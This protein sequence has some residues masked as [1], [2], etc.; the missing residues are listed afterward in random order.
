MSVAPKRTP[1]W[2][3]W[4]F[5]LADGQ[6]LLE[7]FLGSGPEGSG[8]FLTHFNREK[9]AIRLV[10]ASPAQASD[11]I[12]RWNRAASLSHPHLIRILKSGTCV[13]AD[14]SFAYL[15]TEYADEVLAAVLQDRTLTSQ[16]ALE[17]VCPIADVLEYLHSQNLVHGDVSPENVF[18][19][20]DTVKICC[21]A[22]SIGD[23][24]NDVLG[25]A[26]T[27]AQA[28]THRD[29]IDG[30]SVEALPQPFQEIARN[31]LLAD[32]QSRWSSGD[33]ATWLRSGERPSAIHS[34]GTGR[35]RWSGFFAV[36]A[37]VIVALVAGAFFVRRNGVPATPQ[38]PRAEQ[39]AAKPAEKIPAAS[40]RPSE[41]IVHRV[42][43][44]IPEKA[45]KTIRGRATVVIRVAV[46]PSG[47]VTNAR[48]ERGG[49]RY[50][51]KLAMAAA[52]QWRFAPIENS[53]RREWVLKFEITKTAINVIPT[54]RR[55]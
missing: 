26:R 16:E 5:E 34:T 12:E 8:T 39:A 2:R 32:P 51:G 28:L 55:I 21:D 15:V 49:S 46:D 24:A 47:N 25:L 1:D 50:F 40:N 37:L 23:P 7:Q 33:I 11:L 35:K 3:E 27:M 29:A 53:N 30:S 43:P 38:P 52:R 42:L 9:A 13:I 44:E 19:V 20:G 48:L 45:Q 4:E 54:E 14:T 36:V 18:A 17:V 31:T 10:R 22:A 6:F 41:P